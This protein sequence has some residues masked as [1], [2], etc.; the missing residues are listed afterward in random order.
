MF[1]LLVSHSPDLRRL[2]DEGYD[3]KIRSNYL[4]VQQVPYVTAARVVERGILVS[5]LATS[6]NMTAP[7]PYHTVWFVGSVPCDSQGREL[8]AIINDRQTFQVDGGLTASFRFSSKPKEGY[9]D[10]Y[11]K[12][13]SYVNMLQGHA[14]AIDP[15][16]T[17][18]VFPPHQTDDDES[19]FR[20]LDSASSRAQIS[21]TTERLKLGKVAIVGLGGTGSYILD[22]IAKTPIVQIH[23]YDRDT[24]YTH[25]AFRAPGAA[26]LSDL[27]AAP[28][29]VDY[30][31][32]KYDPLR[33][34][35]IAHPVHVDE[36]NI[37]DLRG[38]AFVFLAMDT[39][40]VKKFIIQK[41]EEF[42]VPF[43]D[44]G[45]GVSQAKSDNSIGAQIRTT[46]STDGHR[47]HVWKRLTFAAEEE[48]GYEQNIQIADLD[49]LNAVLAVIKWKKLF[50][51]YTDLE[52]EYSSTYEVDGNHLL[53]EDQKG[54]A[55]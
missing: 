42:G 34:N 33:R 43:I 54:Q 26:Y 22:L 44:T 7:N 49:A 5:E 4:L 55:G 11:D 14:R 51:F 9:A 3:V 16:A 27:E 52:E 20:Y 17:A 31:Q 35:I 10:Y 6:G 21:A 2:R 28:K 24:F 18:Q 19:V 39:G 47:D 50:S 25:N 23:L 29:K 53:N 8:I 12:M 40:P 15:S 48:D 1:E 45:M 32:R 38:M 36:T 46:T 37:E 13:T 30:F 41:L